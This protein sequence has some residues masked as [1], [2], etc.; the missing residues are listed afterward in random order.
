MPLSA[1]EVRSLAQPWMQP[2]R[3]DAPAGAA[4]RDLPVYQR[5]VNEVAKLQSPTAP[6]VSWS[7]VAADGEELLTQ[8]SKDLLAAVYL[9]HA[10]QA[11]RGLP[12]LLAGVALLRGLLE[13]SWDSF[14]PEPTR[15]RAR[16]NAL[17]W[18]VD[19]TCATLPSLP[20]T[21][22][23]RDTVEALAQ[24]SVALAE[25]TRLRFDGKRPA[26]TPLVEAVEELR[27][28]LTAPAAPASAERAAPAAG[29][30]GLAAPSGD[31][32][33]AEGVQAYARELGAALLTA[34][35]LVR[36]AR[37]EDPLG[38]RLH[39]QGLWLAI[40]APPSADAG[41]RSRLPAP[42]PAL[43]EKLQRLLANAKWP[44]LLEEAE[45]ALSQHRLWLDLQRISAQAL[46]VL[47]ETH[48]A[49]RA[50]L[51]AE[52]GALL[53]RLR[54]DS[55][56]LTLARLTFADGTPLADEATLAWL[57]A[58]VQS[59][60][61]DGEG[62]QAKVG[63]DRIAEGREQARAL[64]AKG[65]PTEALALLHALAE[66]TASGE[67][68]FRARLALADLCASNGQLSVAR[69]LYAS[70]DAE[71]LQHGLDTWNPPLAAQCLEGLLEIARLGRKSNA[72]L[73]PEL[74]GLYKRLCRLDPNA[75]LRLGL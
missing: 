35:T 21:T 42:P 19:R 47:G 65:K 51:I 56:T 73:E 62:R 28:S 54:G 61:L 25:L 1:E 8:H 14:F 20:A 23:L 27:Q 41:G 22:A 18:F 4:A 6:A 17:E 68:R 24:E 46:G 26:L 59:A 67:G 70:L 66:H 7:A 72:T 36:R 13:T 29:A 3:P 60:G 45:G 5:L 9:A 53:R 15:L 37:S 40:A 48:G 11:T 33:T 49:A 55:S 74:G 34:G 38:Y 39:R 32:S 58:E 12:G 64:L 75:A 52:L 44:E 16:A 50:A 71:G 43:R 57:E 63:T 69:A 30:P 31:L 10:Q 2:V